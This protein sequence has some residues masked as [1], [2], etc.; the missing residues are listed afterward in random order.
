MLWALN[1]QK[2]ESVIWVTERKDV[3]S[4]AFALL[5]FYLFMRNAEKKTLPVFSSVFAV[6]ALLTK[7]STVPLPGVMIVFLICAWGRK[8]SVKEY[9]KLLLLPLVSCGIILVVSYIITA[10]N[11][12]GG[13][14]RNYLIP[15][16]NIFWYPLTALVPQIHPI[17]PPLLGK[18]CTYW[19]VF[20]CGGLLAFSF[21]FWG[22][23]VGLGWKKILGWF[24][25]TG[26][27]MV[28]VLGMLNY[29]NFD[30][31][32]RYNY[33][34]SIAVCGFLVLLC[35]RTARLRPETYDV[36]RIVL[37]LLCGICFVMS[38]LYLPDWKGT[39]KLF[40][41]ALDDTE[42][43]NVKL[44]SVG[45]HSAIVTGNTGMLGEIIKRTF[46]DH[47]KYPGEQGKAL[48]RFANYFALHCAVLEND[49]DSALPYYRR[50]RDFRKKEVSRF[51]KDFEALYLGYLFR[52]MAL[53]AAACG[54]REESLHYLN[55]YFVFCETYGQKT[56]GYYTAMALK[57][58]LTNDKKLLRITLE[59][60][61]E[62]DPGL[63]R[64]A[65]D[66]EKLKKEENKQ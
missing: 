10:K 16:H 9:L 6:L 65:Q 13:L 64:Y 17:Y 32:D 51:V 47:K 23:K 43:S 21:V 11:F 57:A 60:I 12:P 22:W 2:V 49:Y 24:L 18:I 50:I 59:K 41:R 15:F 33:L 20:V 48:Y 46:R 39:D 5:S 44:Y 52:N 31:C 29:T 4:G 55:K 1:P 38:F 45:A 34:V 54:M 30:Y 27:L 28:P 56:I 8:H 26:G 66:L 37:L 14:E 7:P 62:L 58:Q 53:T 63:T 36:M 35:E 40:A 61:V 25:I 3:L 42:P 19:K